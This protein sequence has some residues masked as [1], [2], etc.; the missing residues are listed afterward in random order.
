MSWTTGSQ[1]V[2]ATT[3]ALTPATITVTPVAPG[4]TAG[5]GP[6]TIALSPATVTVTGVSLGV[7]PGATTAALSPATITV[8][9]AIVDFSRP[10]TT[11]TTTE[12]TGA[13]GGK[14]D[15]PRS[16]RE[17]WRTERVQKELDALLAR[18]DEEI[19]VLV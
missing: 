12:P 2:T 5:G 9:P 16:T 3:L 8:T 4:V 15:V 10:P 14:Y 1:V 19:L 6:Q 17:A 11:T 13:G 18:E 7:T